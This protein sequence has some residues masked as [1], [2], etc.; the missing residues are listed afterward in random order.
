MRQRRI[1]KSASGLPLL[2]AQGWDDIVN[3]ATYSRQGS[4]T[5]PD[6]DYTNIGLLFPQNDTGEKI[7]ISGQMPHAWDGASGKQTIIHPHIHYIQT[8]ATI[9]V[10]TLEYRFYANGAIVP[11]FVTV[12]TAGS[13]AFTYTSGSMLQILR[14]APITL[15]GLG[16]SAWYD[17]ILYRNDNVVTGD[18]LVK[19]FDWHALFNSI[20]SR[21]PERL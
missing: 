3:P 1:A 7:Y 19:G 13:I 5:K 6:F 14:W 18:V 8:G 20:G 16:P 4:N 15:S 11:S 10:F 9:P 17:M 21:Q 2:P 12:S